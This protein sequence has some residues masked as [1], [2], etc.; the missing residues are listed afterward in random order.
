MAFRSMDYGELT[1][2]LRNLVLN[3]LVLHFPSPAGEPDVSGTSVQGYYPLP[4]PTMYAR[5]LAIP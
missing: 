5:K 4:Y 2:A 3:V 1:A